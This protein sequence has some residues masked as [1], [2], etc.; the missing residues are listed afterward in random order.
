M[1]PSLPSSPQRFS[2][3]SPTYEHSSSRTILRKL[4]RT[5][6]PFPHVQVLNC[7]TSN[8]VKK[9]RTAIEQE[10][11]EHKDSDLFSLSQTND[12]VSSKN[13]TLQEFRSFLLK[14]GRTFFEGITGEHVHSSEIDLAGSL[15]EDTDHLLCHDDVVEGRV[16]AFIF[17]LN[18]LKESEGGALRLFSSRRGKPW[19]IATSFQPV[20]GSLVVFKV[21]NKSFH[22]VAEV[23]N[24]RRIAIGGW[25]R[26]RRV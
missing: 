22:D 19:K 12:V 25:Y 8:A 13:K 16:L 21:S 3:I 18:T 1:T 7:L 23:I 24:A 20:E 14:E 4:F 17:Y 26:E 2:W 10:S 6:K 11:F 15:Y 5:A 9:L